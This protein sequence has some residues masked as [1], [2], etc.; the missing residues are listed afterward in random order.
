[1]FAAFIPLAFTFLLEDYQRNRVL[2]FLNPEND[3]LGTGYHITQSKIA[4]GSGGVTGKG[5]MQGTQ[6]RLNFLPEKH[7]DFIFAVFSE[8]FGLIGNAMLLVLYLVN[9]RMTGQ[10]QLMALHGLSPLIYRLGYVMSE[11]FISCA[12]ALIVCIVAAVLR[13]SGATT[14]SG[15]LELLVVPLPVPQLRRPRALQSR[16]L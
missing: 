2:T 1:M 3:P 12:V 8:E 14:F 4:L 13:I 7:T 5:F 10:A 6:T 11:F 16:L 15:F 9:E